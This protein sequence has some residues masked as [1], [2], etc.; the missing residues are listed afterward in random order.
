MRKFTLA[1]AAA[2]AVL[3]LAGLG[4]SAHA[5]NFSADVPVSG[6]TKFKDISAIGSK[7]LSSLSGYRVGAGIGW[8]G[9]GYEAYEGKADLKSCCQVPDFKEKTTFTDVELQFPIPVINV[10]LGYGVGQIK[11]ECTGGC[12][13]TW[14]ATQYYLT[15]GLPIFK[16]ADIHVSYHS[17]TGTATGKT[18]ITAANPNAPGDL[19]N[20]V[21]FIGARA[22]W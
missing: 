6:E 12:K 9:L 5:I 17:I 22:G 10:A 11:D 3:V 13:D 14:D 4:S 8:I 7:T 20:T 15:L 16:V 18:K 19:E 2:V 1:A 21:Y